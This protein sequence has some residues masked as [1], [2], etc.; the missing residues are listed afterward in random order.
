[1]TVTTA[2]DPLA[3]ARDAGAGGQPARTEP[4]SA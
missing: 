1:M 4:V 3:R 2:N